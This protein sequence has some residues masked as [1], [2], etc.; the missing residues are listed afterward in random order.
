MFPAPPFSDVVIASISGEDPEVAI[1]MESIPQDTACEFQLVVTNFLG[2]ASLPVTTTVLKTAR[3]EPSLEVFPDEPSPW[4]RNEVSHSRKWE[5][6][7]K[8]SRR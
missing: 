4:T 6:R 1:D 5:E 8:A 3:D 2:V 7:D